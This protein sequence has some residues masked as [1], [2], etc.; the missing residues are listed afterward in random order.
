MGYTGPIH[1]STLGNHPLANS[2]DAHL[3]VYIT[4]GIK[5]GAMLGPF[6]APPFYPWCQTKPLLTRPKKDFRD[7]R[8]IM[9]LSWPPPLRHIVNGGTPKE[10]YLGLYKKMHLPSAKD[11]VDLIKKAGKGEYL[12]C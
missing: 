5:H 12:Y 10:T 3:A 11:M 2:H 7:R 1:T 9:D 8:M 4:K 6:P